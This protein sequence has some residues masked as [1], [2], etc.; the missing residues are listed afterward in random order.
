M[1]DIYI[2]GSARFTE[3]KVKSFL[4]HYSVTSKRYSDGISDEMSVAC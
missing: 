4:V 1:V 3:I 2:L